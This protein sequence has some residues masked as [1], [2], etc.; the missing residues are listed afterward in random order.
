[1][2]TDGEAGYGGIVNIF[3]LVQEMEDAG[4]AGIHL[5]DQDLPKRCGHMK[6]KRLVS[7]EE[8]S[9]RIQA[10]VDARRD[11]DFVIIAR[12]DAISVTGF[13]DA[14]KRAQRYVDAGADMIFIEGFESREQMV[15]AIKEVKA[16]HMINIVEGGETPNIPVAELGEIGFKVA[17][18]PYSS[19]GAALWAMRNVWAELRR[20]GTT[21]GFEAHM[22]PLSEWMKMTRTDFLL[23]RLERYVSP[24]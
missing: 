5:E 6:G 12:T 7:A 20:A 22:E 11:S 3:R 10:A 9:L 13:K 4:I 24:S 23:G 16:H 19:F 14:I 15:K 2:I 1:V 21:G 17:I 8:H 18:F